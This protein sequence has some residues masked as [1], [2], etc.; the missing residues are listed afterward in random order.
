M[1]K[2]LKRKPLSSPAVG[3][4][5][6]IKAVGWGLSWEGFKE[7]ILLSFECK[8]YER[9]RVIVVIMGQLSLEKCFFL[10]EK[11]NICTSI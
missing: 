5:S 1:E 9:W 10:N 7:N 2:K 6:P 11:K 8:K 3:K 4:G